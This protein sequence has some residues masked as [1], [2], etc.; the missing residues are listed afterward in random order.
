MR[1]PL[2]SPRVLR[3]SPTADD[4]AAVKMEVVDDTLVSIENTAFVTNKKRLNLID[5]TA[6]IA[7]KRRS[8]DFFSKQ[9]DNDMHGYG[10]SSA[11]SKNFMMIPHNKD[12]NNRLLTPLLADP[13]GY[14]L[15]SQPALVSGSHRHDGYGSFRGK[16]VETTLSPLASRIFM[17]P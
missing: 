9:H 2:F 7:T 10:A 14:G 4:N 17:S 6:D 3:F 1:S 8:I 12:G 16:R 11:A 5:D 15:N 13:V